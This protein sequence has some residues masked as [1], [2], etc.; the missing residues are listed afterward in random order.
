MQRLV[1]LFFLVLLLVIFWSCA[2]L[3]GFEEAR[4]VGVGNHGISPSVNAV[5]VNNFFSDDDEFFYPNLDIKYR[6]GLT[7]NLDLGVRASSTFNLGAFAKARLWD[8]EDGTIAIGGGLEFASTLGTSLETHLPL[9]FSYYPNDNITFNFSP[10]LIGLYVL[11]FT[12]EE[13]FT[14]LGANT[15]LLI[16]KGNTR[17]G[18][19]LGFY[20]SVSGS[21]SYLFTAGVGLK[22]KI[23]P[24][25]D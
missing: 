9:F 17:V 16:G 2:S 10:R 15:G 4:T 3:T 19:D 6:Y 14:Y 23:V 25:R 12:D 8:S 22:F 13:R 1:M 20:N 7:E 11:D 5:V 24:R 18:F 21:R